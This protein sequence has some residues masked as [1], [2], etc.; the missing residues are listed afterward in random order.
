MIRTICLSF[1]TPSGVEEGGLHVC[2]SNSE[3]DSPQCIQ[4]EYRM[5]AV[6]VSMIDLLGMLIPRLLSTGEGRQLAGFDVARGDAAAF[7]VA[8][9][10]SCS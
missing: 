3:Y 9:I 5:F 7:L 6:R 1:D 8:P 4:V 10:A 2:I